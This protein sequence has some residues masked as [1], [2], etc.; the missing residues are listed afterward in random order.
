MNAKHRRIVMNRKPNSI[1][2]MLE[3]I[4]S[5]EI[6]G[7]SSHRYELRR[8][9][10]SSKYFEST[11]ENSRF[12]KVFSYTVPLMFGGVMMGVLFFTA[13][14]FVPTTGNNDP[15][16]GQMAQLQMEDVDNSYI[17]VPDDFIDPSNSVVEFADFDPFVSDNSVQ[18]IPLS[19]A[20]SPFVQ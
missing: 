8:T 14:A 1:E 12:E 20:S 13:Q 19:V 2:E 3:Q 10:L 6:P 17:P 5:Q 15:L 18:F 4:G 11:S 9:L 7:D 16:S